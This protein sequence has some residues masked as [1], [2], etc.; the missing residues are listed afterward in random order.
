MSERTAASLRLVLIVLLVANILFFG[1]VLLTPDAH[2]QAR[3]RIE[4]L[5]IN[6]GRVKLLGVATRGPA[7]QAASG[8]ENK[9]ASYRACIQWGPFAAA[10][11]GRAETALTRISAGQRPMQRSLQGTDGVK[12]FALFV[13]EPDAA[14]VARIAELQRAFPGT[15][16]KAGPC[17]S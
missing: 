4:E 2:L 8:K 9:E 7:G 14:V 12:R 5:Q 16:I 3:S 11:V 13:G 1:Y 15:E 17:P 10:D 6:P